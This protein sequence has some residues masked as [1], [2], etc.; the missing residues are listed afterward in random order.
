MVRRLL[1]KAGNVS[2]ATRQTRSPSPSAAL[3]IDP[4]LARG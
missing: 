2:A 4:L 1:P 3:T